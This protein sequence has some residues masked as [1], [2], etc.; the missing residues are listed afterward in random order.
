MLQLN[1]ELKAFWE[2]AD[3]LANMYDTHIQLKISKNVWFVV[4]NVFI[5][6]NF[7]DLAIFHK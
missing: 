5:F 1:L 3:I 7:G 6:T 4:K 2:Q